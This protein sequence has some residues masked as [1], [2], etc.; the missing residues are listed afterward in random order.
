MTIAP[1]D[2][3]TRDRLVEAAGEVFAEL[4]FRAATIRDISTRAGANVA[5][6]NYHFG[7]KQALY[8]AVLRYA[9][10]CAIE[11]YPPD[12]GLPPTAAPAKRLEAFVRSFLLRLLDTGRPAWHA[13]LMARELAEP[14]PALDVLVHE[15]IQPHFLGL[16][17]I[18]RQLMGDKSA[19]A[20]APGTPPAPALRAVCSSI[21]GQCLFYHF[22][23]PITARLFPNQPHTAA[24]VDVLAAHITRFSLAGIRATA[25]Q[26]KRRKT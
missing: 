18:V 22:G 3:T 14:T 26:T 10:G 12:M 5:A 9:H 17:G 8:T 25:P 4:G 15:H 20:P 11:K 21:V 19:A 2:I 1:S 13:R 23:A 6:V 7:D 24:D 16:M